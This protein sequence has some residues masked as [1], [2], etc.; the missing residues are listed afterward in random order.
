M[1]KINRT[2]IIFLVLLIFTCLLTGCWDYRDIDKRLILS[3]TAIDHIDNL[4]TILIEYAQLNKFKGES[5][6]KPSSQ[7]TAIS[8]G[9][10]SNF[11]EARDQLDRKSPF[12][13]FLGATRINILGM[14]IAKNDIGPYM[15]RIKRIFDY[16]KTLLVV[17]SRDPIREIYKLKPKNDISM[18]F[19]IDDLVRQLSEAGSS[20]YVTA[21]E[22]LSSIS[23][24]TIGYVLPYIC[25]SGDSVEYIGLAVMKDSK[26]QGYFDPKES[27]G[28][29]Y[30]LGRRPVITQILTHPKNEKNLLSFETK[31]KRKSIKTDYVNGKVSIHIKINLNAQLIY[32]YYVDPIDDKTKKQLEDE[33]S[34]EVK[35][36]IVAPL[37]MTQSYY[38]SDIYGFAKN[39]RADFP[40]IYRNID[41]T[42]KY[43]NAEIS[44]DVHTNITRLGFVDPN[45]KKQY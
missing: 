27:R 6:G 28:I 19:M 14:G 42:D 8:E 43:S 23:T 24:G 15:N 9:T 29:I 32:Q 12:P 1:G 5:E 44:V 30:I 3:S 41:W 36:Q 7:G 40:S 4:D 2:I 21:G 17:I 38:K 20:I 33:L 37:H 45:A 35:K 26:F 10:G 31:V 22:V 25:K 34:D 11:D 13:I 39:F 18:G 16:R